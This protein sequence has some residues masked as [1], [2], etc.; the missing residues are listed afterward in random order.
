M[1]RET[2]EVT[3]GKKT[4]EVKQALEIPDG[5]HFFYT[6]PLKHCLIGRETQR[7]AVLL[8]RACTCAV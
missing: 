2:N 7:K 3:I 6:Y 5:V 8:S 1:H 4:N